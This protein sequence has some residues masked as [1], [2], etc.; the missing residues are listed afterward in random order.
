MKFSVFWDVVP[1]SHGVID[2]RLIAL[3][4]EAI[5]TAETSVTFNVTTRRY[6]P[7]DSKLQSYVRLQ[8]VASISNGLLLLKSGNPSRLGLHDNGLHPLVSKFRTKLYTRYVCFT[9]RLVHRRD[10]NMPS[11][12]RTCDP[13]VLVKQARTRFK[14]R[15]R[16]VQNLEQKL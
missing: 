10:A 12:I 8:L 15:G 11:G 7:E 1:C 9:G 16:C 2:R 4:M 6:I 14:S 3:M 13:S 5:H